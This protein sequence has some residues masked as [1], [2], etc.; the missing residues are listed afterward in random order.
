MH[1]KYNY[2]Q[3]M[4]MVWPKKSRKSQAWSTVDGDRIN[5]PGK[6]AI[7]TAE[8]MVENL[9]FNSVIS[10]EGARFMTMDISNF[11]LITPLSRPEYIWI[12]LSDIPDKIIKDYNLLK[13]ATKDE[14]IYIKANKGMYW[15][16]TRQ[17]PSQ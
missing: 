12:K 13:K 3:F 7:P 1:E 9:I 15:P 8:I 14:S 2:G 10:M 4:C 17:T 11:Y 16:T 6:V 5:Y